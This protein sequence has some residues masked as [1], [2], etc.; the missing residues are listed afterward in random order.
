MNSTSHESR[1]TRALGCAL[2][3]RLGQR[4]PDPSAATRVL[5]VG[6]PQASAEQFFA[7]LERHG[8]LSEA[9][10]LEPSVQLVSIGDHFDFGPFERRGEAALAGIAILSW[11]AAHAPEQVTLIAGNHDLARVAEL[12]AIDDES[13]QTAA[14][15]AFELYANPPI[16]Q[17]RERAFL[18]DYPMFPSVEV[19]ARDLCSFCVEQRE[20]VTRLLRARRFRLAASIA[21]HL[22]VH[23]GATEANLEEIGL[24]PA[25]R[26]DAAAIAERLNAVFDQ[27]V[28][29]W[30]AEQP[31]SIPGL[32]APGSAET[33]EPGGFLFHRPAQPGGHMPKK[34][35]ARRFDP[36]TLPKG[37]SQVVG[38]VRDPKCRQLLGSWVEGSA[39]REGRLRHLSAREDEVSYRYGLPTAEPEA[40]Q[41]I[42]IDGGMH[43][44]P[45]EHY[46]LF[47]VSSEAE[48]WRPKTV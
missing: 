25:K 22:F 41:L 8:A 34:D 37:L 26:S 6:D 4:A 16:A 3:A 21:D 17:E 9:G 35:R 27:A 33:G 24:A 42:F 15:R 28:S 7:I 38:H 2:D 45:A 29:G 32:F 18:R 30:S 39:S 44:V 13:F 47:E 31:F 36:R 19:A 43:H 46:E 11:L 5:A 48:P 1:A 14:E 40:A 23:A 20:L 12:H 10:W